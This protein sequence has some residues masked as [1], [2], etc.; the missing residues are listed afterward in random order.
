MS[1]DIIINSSYGETRIAILENKVLTELYFELPENERMVGDIYYGRVAKV[2]KGMQAAFINIGLRN[3]AFLHFS[4]VGDNYLKF[5][6]LFD[7]KKEKKLN[8]NLD[9]SGDSPLLK[10]GQPIL[11]QI[12]KEPMANK[13][14]RVTTNISLAGRLSV[15]I[16]FES[17][18]GVSRKIWKRKEKYRLKN[19]GRKVKPNG[20]GVVLRTVAEGKEEAIFRADLDNLQ[21]TWGRIKKTIRKVDAPAVVHKDMSMLSSVVRDL[22]TPDVSKLV[23]DSRK[24]HGQIV[25]YLKELSPQLAERVEFY[26]KKEPIYDYYSIESEVQK[27]LSRKVWLKSGG[28]IF[29]DHTEALTAI[30]VNSG[31]F[32]GK[33]SHD[34]NSL[35]INLEASVEIARQLRLRDIGGIIILD[36]ID[37]VEDANR[38]KLEAAYK[39]ELRKDRSQANV[40]SLSEFGIIE[41]TRQRVRS[42]LLLTI[43]ESCPA[44]MGTGRIINK[45]TMAARIERWVKRYRTEGGDRSVQVFIH[46]ELSKFMNKGYRN[47]IRRI[48]WKH[49]MRIKIM[50]D[51]NMSMDDFRVFDK[52]GDKE[53][54]DKY[55]A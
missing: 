30:D 15:L 6:S 21:K 36:F 19:I 18:V 52:T 32:H 8:Q 3:D 23:V 1:K 49:W 12:T 24:M 14:A 37:M 2:V 4:D 7:P 39:A 41:M 54:T 13:G 40:T 9:Y 10:T 44:C 55:M 27:S 17:I 26:N 5:Q 34:A 35:K 20:F 46:P 45:S 22:F 43:S 53:L 50:E 33:K 48:N 42:A 28:Y 29:I 51:E 16:P 38:K 47:H 31:R 11:V 25:K